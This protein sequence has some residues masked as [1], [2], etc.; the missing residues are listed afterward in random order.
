MKRAL[1][2]QEEAG[3]SFTLEGDPSYRDFDQVIELAYAVPLV[4]ELKTSFQ[5][6]NAVKDVVREFLERRTFALPAGIPLHFGGVMEPE[7][8]RIA[9]GNIAR[10]EVITGAAKALLPA[11]R[12]AI[13]AERT[14][15]QAQLSERRAAELRNY[16]ALK[17]NVVQA[18]RRS[19]FQQAAVA[20]ADE[21]A[22]AVLV[23]R[24]RDVTGWLYNDR[25]GVGFSIPYDWQG[26]TSQYFPDFVARAK[27]GE[28]FHNFVIEVKGRLDDRDRA[29]AK[30]GEAYCELLTEHDREPWHYLM[31][32]ENKP[33]GREDIDWWQ[34]QSATEIG[35]LLRRHESLPLL[36]DAGGPP[37]GRPFQLLDAPPQT[38]Q[39]EALPVYDLA[40]AAG[41]F[42]ASQT[43]D[44][45]GW[46]LVKT[47]RTTDS[48]M[49]V[50]Q[51]VGKSMEQ[52]VPDGSY[53]LLRRFEAAV[54]PS[55]VALDRRRVIV[56]LREGAES[57]LGGRY[58]LKRW[59]VSK[60]DPSEGVLEVELCPDNR[61]YRSIRM[62]RSDGEIRVV[63][64]LLEVLT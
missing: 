22:F 15:S 45:V 41:G 64:E 7:A 31:L 44:V 53:C 58:T 30:A 24:A 49:F 59:R 47:R 20:N 27:L 38:G 23:D 9:L 19:S 33:A 60:L 3:Q 35:D 50:A 39:R 11:L 54:A 57:D 43:P 10:Q 4:R 56:E 36:P 2:H 40:A 63:A 55:P 16:Q 8:A 52:G 48:T 21:L 13:V 25:S 61:S 34:Q 6:K 29:K 62:R 12:K 1:E 32:I 37:S 14:A 5:H 18:L 51:V 28:V 17:K 26:R 46:V 42:S